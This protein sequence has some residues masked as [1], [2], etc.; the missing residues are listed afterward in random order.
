VAIYE[1]P[2]S[3]CLPQKAGHHKADV[4]NYISHGISKLDEDGNEYWSVG[5]GTSPWR[6][7]SGPLAAFTSTIARAREGGIDP[8]IGRGSEVIADPGS[9]RRRKNNP[10]YVGDPESARRL[11]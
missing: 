6:F 5:G 7:E 9:R 3:R 10:I 8:L 2:H 11:Y 4:L 1:E